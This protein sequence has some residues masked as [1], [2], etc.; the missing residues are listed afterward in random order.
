MHDPHRLTPAS[1]PARPAPRRSTW[2][3]AR[4]RWPPASQHARHLD[5]SSSYQAFSSSIAPGAVLCFLA[6]QED[7]QSQGVRAVG[8]E[9]T[10]P[11]GPVRHVDGQ[12]VEALAVAEPGRD[13]GRL[14]RGGLLEVVGVG[15]GAL[16][17]A[18]LDRGR[19]RSGC[20]GLWKKAP[21]VIGMDRG[22]LCWRSLA[23]VHT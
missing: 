18:L 7:P 19:H 1:A 15:D 6:E 16:E 12:T 17:D 2:R 14:R 3:S 20:G 13:G 8:V 11:A 9:D 21:G 10:L 5:L 4:A 23:C 22:R